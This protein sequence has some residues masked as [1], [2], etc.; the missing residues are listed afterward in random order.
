MRT[1]AALCCSVTAEALF[2]TP[3][4]RVDAAVVHPLE[5]DGE[6]LIAL[7]FARRALAESLGAARSVALVGSDSRLVLRGWA[8][9]AAVGTVGVTADLGGRWFT[10]E[11]LEEELRRYPP[12]RLLADSLM[13]RRE[14]WWYLPRLVCRL[15]G[16]VLESRVAARDDP[17]TTGVLA[18]D[19]ADGLHADTVE[20][21][22]LETERVTVR[23]LARAT[24]A[25]ASDPACLLLHD[26]SVPDLEQRSSLTAQGRLEGDRLVVE[27]RR[28]A[29]GLPPPAGLR[30]RWRDA[31]AFARDCRREVSRAR[32]EAAASA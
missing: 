22:G 26:F 8:P 17:R 21:A 20:V 9:G 19:A 25:G 3:D 6:P 2:T 24:I 23:S 29:L 15:E 28:G 14:H 10:E 18:W 4:G 12:S 11:L 30:R 31:R 13:Q 32:A 27:H 5:L 16:V 1:T 7:P